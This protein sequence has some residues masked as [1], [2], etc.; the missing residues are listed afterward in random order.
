MGP[1]IIFDKS[2]LQSISVDESVFLQQFFITNVTPLF[3]V[4][5]LGDL[6]LGKHKSGKPITEIIS[7]LAIKVPST[8][9]APNIHHRRLIMGNLIGMDVEMDGRIIREGGIEKVDP[10]GN[11]GIHYSESQEEMALN[12][13][14]KREYFAV[15]KL[16]SKSWRNMLSNLTF[17]HILGIIKNLLPNN[18]KLSNYSQVKKFVDKFIT[19]TKIELLL[20]LVI[21]F[22]GINQ[23]YYHKALQR[24]RRES[25]SDFEKFAPYAAYVLKIDLFFYI[26]MF[27][28]L[29]SKNRP[30]HKID[31]AYLYYLPFCNVFVSS[32]KLHKRIVNFFLRKDQ[33]FVDG[34]DFK[35]GLSKLNEYYLHYLDQI[36]KEGFM[37]FAPQPP[38]DL[39]NTVSKI[40]DKIFPNWRGTKLDK[41]KERNP[42][43]EKILLEKLKRI[44]KESIVVD[45]KTPMDDIHH[46]IETHKVLV[47]K[48]KWRILPEGIE[49]KKSQN[50]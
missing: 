44:Q 46:I 43:E 23:N 42:E 40:W 41:I 38:K 3:Y 18:E 20:Y 48:G 14:H 34:P 8:S 5:T 35:R 19:K 12:R 36:N 49:N 50:K 13:W 2:F 17:D 47:Q 10:D 33:I 21:E 30:S 39:D 11:V 32:D 15:E 25:I 9:V 4:E 7:A 45:R 29:E 28:G 24:W 31:L 16:F 22:S 6:D 27:L 37:R 26:C 1:T